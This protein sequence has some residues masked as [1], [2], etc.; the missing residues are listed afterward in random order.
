MAPDNLVLLELFEIPYSYAWSMFAVSETPQTIVFPNLLRLK[1][2][3]TMTTEDNVEYTK[4]NYPLVSFPKLQQLSAYM[5]EALVPIIDYAILPDHIQLLDVSGS[6]RMLESIKRLPQID[7]LAMS[8]TYKKSEEISDPFLL[9]DNILCKAA[10]SCAATIC[11]NQF[12]SNDIYN[13]TRC[14]SLTRMAI[15]T[16]VVGDCIPNILM[17]MPNLKY[18]SFMKI[19]QVT[20]DDSKYVLDYD[21]YKCTDAQPLNLKLVELCLS[22]MESSNTTSAAAVFTKYLLPRLPALKALFAKQLPSLTVNRFV[23]EYSAHYP[24]LN[25]I[26]MKLG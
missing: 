20:S 13:S 4:L 16:K 5:D 23:Q 22:F 15:C 18:V 11:I 7:K 26:V 1:V 2:G 6:M 24:H 3:Y 25:N 14:F 9:M 17:N 19:T 8:L 21:R 10:K 12:I